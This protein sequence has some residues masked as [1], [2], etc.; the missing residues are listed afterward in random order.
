MAGAAA[1]VSKALND[2]HDATTIGAGRNLGPRLSVRIHGRRLSIVWRCPFVIEKGAA[3]GEL[4]G[5][6]AV[7]ATNVALVYFHNGYNADGQ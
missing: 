6:V 1:A 7:G 5:A 2:A 4:G 3:K